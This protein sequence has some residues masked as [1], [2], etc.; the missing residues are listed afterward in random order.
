MP[1]PWSAIS[2][3][4]SFSN[5]AQLFAVQFQRQFGKS[6]EMIV[7]SID[8]GAASP[9]K[10]ELGEQLTNS[11]LISNLTRHAGGAKCQYK[12]SSREQQC[13]SGGDASDIAKS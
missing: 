6:Q 10:R 9:A 2:F 4:L 8:Y 1:L 11:G 12:L 7:L 13:G 5:Q 3:V